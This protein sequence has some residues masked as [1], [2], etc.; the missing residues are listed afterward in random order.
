[1]KAPAVSLLGTLLLLP[2]LACWSARAQ[3][4]AWVAEKYRKVEA[5]IPMRDGVR[6]FTS[7]YIPKDTL[8]RYPVLL[9]RTPYSV[10]PYGP[11]DL[12]TPLGPSRFEA[13]E[14][15]IFV[16]Q[17]VRGRYMSEGVFVDVRPYIEKKKSAE[18]VDE[19]SDTYDT[20]EWIL[21]NI[22]PTNRK[23]GITGISYPG[24]YTTMGIIDAHPALVAASPQ[25]PIG[26]WF[27]GDD[28]HHNGAL[29]LAETFSLFANFGQLRA[30]PLT[31]YPSRFRFPNY[32]AY[33]FF[34]SMGPLPE[35]ERLYMRDSIP[36]WKDL[37]EHDTYDSF[38]KARSVFP[39]LNRITPA[40]MT[41]G[42]WFD[43]E[44]LYGALN[45]YKTIEQN[46]PK[47]FNILVM[48]PW[49]HGQWAR[50]S[51]E[52]LGDITFGSKTSEWFREHVQYP[53]YRYFLK[54]EGSRK[55]AEATVFETG[56]N[57]WHMLDAWPPRGT[58]QVSFYLGSRGTVTR[59]GPRPKGELFSE[60]LSDPDHPVPH[61]DEITSSVQPSYMVEDQRFASRRPDVLTFTSEP[62][63][64]EVTFAGPITASLYVSTSGTDADWIV[65]VIDVFPDDTVSAEKTTRPLGGYQMLVRGDVMRGKFRKSFSKPQP[66]RP[67]QVTKV[68]FTL[69]DV[70]HRF[71]RGHK[72][73]IQVQSSWFPL[74]DRNPQKFV[75]IYRASAEDFQ[76]ATHKVFHTAVYPS[77]ITVGLWTPPAP[78]PEGR[79]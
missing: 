35:A 14:G 22:R 46:N 10:K 27:L 39:H 15:Y 44:D 23:V 72:I 5:M 75:N 51:G 76:K 17:D 73:M 29:F 26:D 38:W 40:I 68:E 79:P 54:G 12:R 42:G 4:S 50:D 67:G 74:V 65:K 1:M 77:K 9:T 61:S 37:M 56:A 58:R 20:I 59:G 33:S 43:K 64:E 57:R 52:R 49:S 36:Y 25:A 8:T 16:Y 7:I 6:L 41:V 34:L 69:Q 13:E 19:S 11:N 62:L 32:D 21:R 63:P 24:F 18:D 47:T 45:T 55:F 2:S 31:E 71:K 70:L 53:F 66:F 78:K 28:D 3:D 60:F 48:G 30:N